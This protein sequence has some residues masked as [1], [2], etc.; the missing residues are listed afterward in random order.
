MIGLHCA[1]CGSGS[2]QKEATG[3]AAGALADAEMQSVNYI[4]CVVTGALLQTGSASQGGGREGS[5][6]KGEDEG[7][8]ASVLSLP[9]VCTHHDHG[10]PIR[11]PALPTAQ[12]LKP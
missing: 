2:S 3:C 7:V 4:V 12:P 1:I 8:L 11:P 6:R 5:C 9:L 10:L